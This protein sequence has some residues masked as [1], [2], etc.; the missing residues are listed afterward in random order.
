MDTYVAVVFNSKSRAKEALHD[1]W[2]LDDA[3]ALTVHGSTIVH[4]DLEGHVHVASKHDD[5]G[6]RTAVGIG[7]G[8]LVGLI[9]GPVGVAAGVIGGVTG[10]A[11]GFSADATK[12]DENA[13]AMRDARFVLSDDQTAI[14]AEVSEDGEATLDRAMETFGGTV[15][16]RALGDV[17]NDALFGHGYDDVLYPY[18]FEPHFANGYRVPVSS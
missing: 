2:R 17:R 4:R 16:R 9:A 14:V 11:V 7:I 6:M 1:L 3:G 12:S 15:Y 5:V 13:V 8:V 18:D 10:A